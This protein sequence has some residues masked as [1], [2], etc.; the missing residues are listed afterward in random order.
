[1][2]CF[3]IFDHEGRKNLEVAYFVQCLDHFARMVAALDV[4]LQID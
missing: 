4:C 1:M 2:I 3:I